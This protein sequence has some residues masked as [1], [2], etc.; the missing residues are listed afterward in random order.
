MDGCSEYNQNPMAEEDVAKNAFI[1]EWIAFAYIIMSFG[2][3][4]GPPSFSKAQL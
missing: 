1:T 4:N 3:N 2:L